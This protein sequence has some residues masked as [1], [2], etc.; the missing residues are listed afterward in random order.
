[1]VYL[2]ILTY[3]DQFLISIGCGNGQAT[4]AFL[5]EGYSDVTGVDYS[6]AAIQLSNKIAKQRNANVIFEVITTFESLFM[7]SQDIYTDDM[8]TRIDFQFHNH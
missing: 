1:M 8:Y 2:P 4:F 5:E 6:E 3:L 7:P